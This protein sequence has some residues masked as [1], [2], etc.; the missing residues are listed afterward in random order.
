MSVSAGAGAAG[1]GAGAGE[2]AGEDG[3]E[4]QPTAVQPEEPATPDKSTLVDSYLSATDPSYIRHPHNQDVSDICEC[5]HEPLT[6]LQQEGIMVCDNCGYQELLLVEQNRPILRLPSAKEG[7]HYSYKRINHFREWV[8]Q[9]Q[10]KES[11]DIP[12]DI[13]ERI[14]AEIRKEKI[15][16]TKRITYSKMREILKKLKLNR[17]FEHANYIIH[18]INGTPTPNFPPELEEKLFAMFRQTQGPFLKYCPASRKNYLSYSYVL[19]QLL[20]ILGI[21]EYLGHFQLLKSREKI[22]N[23]DV[24]W[25]KITADLGWPFYSSV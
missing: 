1:A 20:R 23:H 25:K 8:A 22:F 3:G 18:R 12:E 14:L 24:L 17:Y 13:F 15:R 7:S 10:G 16:D 6:C 4:Q 11:T 9:I 19:A 5:C 2:I 21:H